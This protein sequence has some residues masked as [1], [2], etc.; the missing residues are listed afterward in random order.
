MCRERHSQFATASRQVAAAVR[1]SRAP[2]WP[3]RIGQ[4]ISKSGWRLTSL[5]ALLIVSGIGLAAGE[6]RIHAASR[7]AHPVCGEARPIPCRPD[8]PSDRCR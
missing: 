8:L 7:A 2:L 3:H 5:T 6:M 1:G 4:G